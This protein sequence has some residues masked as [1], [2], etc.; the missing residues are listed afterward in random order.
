MVVNYEST[1]AVLKYIAKNPGQSVSQIVN[2]L[3]GK[4]SFL[5]FS[6]AQDVLDDLK[7]ITCKLKRD[8]D[9]MYMHVFCLAN[10][11]DVNAIIKDKLCNLPRKK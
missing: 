3:E 11:V 5:E 4:V 2:G 8:R 10:A 1:V 7:A 6:G 9:G